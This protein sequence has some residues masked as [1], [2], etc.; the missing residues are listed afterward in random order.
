MRL[1]RSAV[2]LLMRMK[3]NP[4]F[5]AQDD[6]AAK[7]GPRFERNGVG[8]VRGLADAPLQVSG[9]FDADEQEFCLWRRMMLARRMVFDSRDRPHAPRFERDL[10]GDMNRCFSWLLVGHVCGASV[11]RAGWISLG[12]SSSGSS[13]SSSSRAQRLLHLD[14]RA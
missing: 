3:R 7:D 6:A 5:G 8:M 9:A 2:V 14:S 1:C 12:E 13:D 11:C 4:I 10:R